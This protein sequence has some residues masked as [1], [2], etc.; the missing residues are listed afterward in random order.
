MVKRHIRSSPFT[1]VSALRPWLIL[2]FVWLLA[3][4]PSAG[5]GPLDEV[6]GPVEKTVAPVKETVETV[7]APVTSPPPTREAPG[8]VPATPPTPPAATPPPPPRLPAP[9]KDVESTVA[10]A[11]E[12]AKHTVESASEKVGGTAANAGA[13]ADSD[14]PVSGAN[15]T[16]AGAPGD[17]MKAASGAGSESDLPQGAE[18]P[19]TGRGAPATPPDLADLALHGPGP[20]NVGGALIPPIATSFRW[21]FVF[22]WPAI[23]LTGPFGNLVSAWSTTTLRLFS[24]YG[25]GSL[26]GEPRG[27]ASPAAAGTG[28]LGEAAAASHSP[29]SFPP[30]SPWRPGGGGVSAL[31]Y[32]LFALAGLAIAV[33]V[34]RHASEEKEPQG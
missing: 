25:P 34:R 11:G 6:T 12:A 9:V 27:E 32:L 23:A 21:P 18:T 10:S 20:G 26:G 31:F 15:A 13:P 28:A 5:A 4:A 2:S 7:T 33:T 22:V 24:K 16:I 8:P 1:P 3:F 14:L 30:G 29:F 19:R 17:G